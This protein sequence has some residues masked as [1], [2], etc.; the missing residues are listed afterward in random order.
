M[1]NIE[2]FAIRLQWRIIL[3]SDLEE[4]LRDKRVI[5]TVHTDMEAF[6]YSQPLTT[7]D[8]APY[9]DPL[10]QFHFKAAEPETEISVHTVLMPM[11]VSFCCPKNFLRAA[12]LYSNS[13]RSCKA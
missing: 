6:I 11:L 2:A 8:C 1:A 4:K 12:P 9:V 7:S 5:V 13:S 10:S 3:A